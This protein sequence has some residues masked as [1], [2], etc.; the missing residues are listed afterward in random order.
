MPG[1][2][3]IFCLYLLYTKHII[4]KNSIQKIKSA[5][6]FYTNDIWR[7]SPEKEQKLSL[8]NRIIRLLIVG[9]RRFTTKGC[10]QKASALTYYSLL[11]VVPVVAMIFGIAKGFGFE[12]ILEKMLLEKFADKEAILMQVFDFSNSLLSNTHGGMIAGIG[13]IVLFWSVMK[14]L[15]NVEMTLN[16]IW[17][18]KAQRSIPRMVSD[19]FSIMFLAPVLLIISNSATL[20]ISTAVPM[21]ISKIPVLSHSVGLVIFLFKLLPFSLVWLGFAIIYMIM[22]NTKV[23]FKAAFIGGVIS[24]IIFQLIQWVYIRFQIGVASYNAIYGSFA[25][26]PLFLIWLQLSWFVVLLGASVSHIV[27]HG[28]HAEYDRD[29][30]VISHDQKQKLSLWITFMIVRNFEKGQ[31][32]V[33][34]KEIAVLAKVNFMLLKTILKRLEHAHIITRVHTL[35]KELFLY[36]PAVSTNLLS[37]FYFEEAFDTVGEHKIEITDNEEYDKV[38]AFLNKKQSF[39]SNS[40]INILIK[41]L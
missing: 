6:T 3:G 29:D 31:K 26:L 2:S 37:T 17:D 22:P 14:V 12:K 15:N 4:M 20:Y 23:T 11:S 33:N 25:A 32:P 40:E 13:L 38:S 30:I 16:D 19:Y 1:D 27:Q 39:F 35:D 36:Q 21:I 5:I 18:V 28:Y 24:G 9:W 34:V 10:M 8:I 41:D 7:L